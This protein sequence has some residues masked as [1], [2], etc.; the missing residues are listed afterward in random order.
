MEELTKITE[1]QLKGLQGSVNIM[2]AAAVRLGELELSK[3]GVIEQYNQHKELLAGIQIELE[4]EY[5]NVSININDGS[6]TP[7]ED[8]SN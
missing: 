4:K 5:G 6:I 1:E 2:Q 3:I 7:V 8:A